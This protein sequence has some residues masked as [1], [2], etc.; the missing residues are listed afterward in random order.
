MTTEFA[1]QVRNEWNKCSLWTRSA[2]VPRVPVHGLQTRRRR[3]AAGSRQARSGAEPWA[4]HRCIRRSWL[5]S[6]RQRYIEYL[7][8]VRL[9]RQTCTSTGR[10]RRRKGPTLDAVIAL[11][12]RTFRFMSQ[13]CLRHVQTREYA[14]PDPVYDDRSRRSSVPW[15]CGTAIWRRFDTISSGLS[16]LPIVSWSCSKRDIPTACAGPHDRANGDSER[17]GRFQALWNEAVTATRAVTRLGSWHA[18]PVLK[19]SPGRQSQNGYTV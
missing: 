3:T 15:T 4:A 6:T 9:R 19:A 12:P 11:G 16:R 2:F 14:C 17:H 1:S 13:N 18:N 8:D 10:L 5:T 7:E